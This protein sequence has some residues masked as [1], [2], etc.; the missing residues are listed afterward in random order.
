M[1]EA[2]MCVKDGLG[3]RKKE[4]RV[5]GEEGKKG[6]LRIRQTNEGGYV[7]E[8]VSERYSSLWKEEQDKTSSSLLPLRM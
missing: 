2:K 5:K 8:K 4:I 7:N 3:E 6:G 1:K